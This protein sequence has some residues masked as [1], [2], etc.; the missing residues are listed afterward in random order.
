M[1]S[2]AYE[3]ILRVQA[4]DL[5][6]AQLRHRH[7]NL[8]VRAEL[9]AAEATLAEASNTVEGIEERKHTLDRE[10]KRHSDDVELIEAKRAE[11]DGKLYGGSVTASK[12]LL[13]LQDEAASLLGRQR[14]I[15]DQELEIM[16]QLDA[17]G[18]E[19]TAARAVVVEADGDVQKLTATLAAAAA[20]IDAEIEEVAAERGA[21]AAPAPPDLL[22]RY[23]QL[24]AQFDGVAVARLENGACDGCHIKLSAVAIDQLAKASDDDVVTCE[25]CGRLLVQ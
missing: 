1:A 21:A 18:D 9:A 20:E 14:G 6:I 7:A 10:L 24:S 12:D 8:P 25:E 4:L 17:I 13:A 19:L 22:A 16:E 15:E 23:E 3:Q 11:I 2:A 5:T